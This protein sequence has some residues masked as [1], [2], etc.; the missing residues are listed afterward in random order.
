MEETILEA[1]A[2]KEALSAQLADPALYAGA[3]EEVARVTAEFREVVERVD[4]LYARW[5]EL[6]EA[7]AAKGVNR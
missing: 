2:R 5:A 7:A 3:Q 6:E 1:E 4:A